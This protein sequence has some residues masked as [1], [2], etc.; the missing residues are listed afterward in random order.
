MKYRKKETEKYNWTI[1]YI[2]EELKTDRHIWAC[3]G[4]AGLTFNDDIERFKDYAVSIG[5]NDIVKEIITHK[6]KR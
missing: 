2:R 4:S 6:L 3:L 5:A 1:K